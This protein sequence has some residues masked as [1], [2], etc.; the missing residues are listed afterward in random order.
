MKAPRNPD[1]ATETRRAAGGADLENGRARPGCGGDAG[2]S[3]D[4][5][6]RFRLVALPRT[7]RQSRPRPRRPPSASGPLRAVRRR[8]STRGSTCARPLQQ[9][10]PQRLALAARLRSARAQARDA[11]HA[12]DRLRRSGHQRLLAT[13]ASAARIQ[14]PATGDLLPARYIGWRRRATPTTSTTCR[15]PRRRTP[16]KRPRRNWPRKCG[17]PAKRWPSRCYHDTRMDWGATRCYTVRTFET[18]AGLTLQSD[19][20]PRRRASRWSDTFAA[21]ARRRISRPSSTEGAINLIWEPNTEKDIAG[22]IVLRGTPAAGKL[23]YQAA[24]AG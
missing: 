16:R 22:Y 7:R 13:A 8:G 5:G 18:I 1:A 10:R 2:G 14:P 24:D 4:A 20:P 15:R 9:A 12:G 6:R 11:R 23:G 19:A 17:S 21:G 3:V